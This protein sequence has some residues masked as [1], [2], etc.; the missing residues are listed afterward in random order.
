M[1]TYETFNENKQPNYTEMCDLWKEIEDNMYGVSAWFVMN[2]D[3]ILCK[4]LSINITENDLSQIV[5]LD[6][7]VE[8]NQTEYVLIHDYWSDEDSNGESIEIC[9][10]NTINFSNKDSVFNAIKNYVNDPVAW[11]RYIINKKANTFNL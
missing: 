4:N 5:I 7:S 1:T 8:M 11:K 3:P 6:D 9:N 10:E 2:L